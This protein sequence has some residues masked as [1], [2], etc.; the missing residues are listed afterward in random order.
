M[1]TRLPIC[2]FHSFKLLW[3]HALF[4]YIRCNALNMSVVLKFRRPSNLLKTVMICLIFFFVKAPLSNCASFVS[5]WSYVMSYGE[6]KT[7]LRAS[8]N[9]TTEPAHRGLVAAGAGCGGAPALLQASP[10]P[11]LRKNSYDDETVAMLTVRL[12]RWWQKTVA[13]QTMMCED[14]DA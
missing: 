5:F 8:A 6:S 9:V 13:V 3:S 7:V 4:T 2:L 11:C 1:C 10:W 14:E 12:R